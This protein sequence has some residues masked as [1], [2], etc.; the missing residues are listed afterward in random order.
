MKT[1]ALL[2]LWEILCAEEVDQE[3]LDLMALKKDCYTT[4]T[5]DSGDMREVIGAP[6]LGR[7]QNAAMRKVKPSTEAQKR[8]NQKQAE[9]RMLRLAEANFGK[10]DYK[11]DL[12]FEDGYLPDESEIQKVIRNFVRRLN[13]ARKRLAIKG[14]T[15]Y[16]AVIEGYSEGSKKKRLHVHMLIDGALGRELIREIWGMGRINCVELDPEGFGGLRRLISYLSKDPRGSKRWM[17]SKGLKKPKE[18]VANRKINS[19]MMRRVLEGQREAERILEKLNPG[20]KVEQFFAK[21]NPYIPGY[22]H[23][24]CVMRKDKKDEQVYSGRKSGN[25]RGGAADA[26]RRDVRDVSSG[27]SQEVRKRRRKA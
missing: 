23:F 1:D 10:D 2:K 15:K 25:G 26:E 5:I 27:G 24:Y 7:L 21:E 9:R 12:T 11:L 4:K 13:A 16:I 17:C 19:R 14:N 22:V 20:Y 18:R 6:V 3:C 8:Y